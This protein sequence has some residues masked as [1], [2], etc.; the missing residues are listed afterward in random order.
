MSQDRFMAQDRVKGYVVGSDKKAGKIEW[1]VKVKQE[2]HP[3]DGEKFIVVDTAENIQLESGMN[4]NFEIGWRPLTG[5]KNQPIAKNVRFLSQDEIDMDVDHSPDIEEESKNDFIIRLA[6]SQMEGRKMHAWF[7]GCNSREEVDEQIDKPE[8]LVDFMAL[9]VNQILDD[10]P[11]VGLD[12]G[13]QM[14]D[15]MTRTNG[16]CEALEHFVKAVY[17]LGQRNPTTT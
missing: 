3:W 1:K 8:T 2:G 13:F 16:L 17:E 4:V 11:F 6:I 9:D 5:E 14:I 10:N 15:L 7:T 12:E